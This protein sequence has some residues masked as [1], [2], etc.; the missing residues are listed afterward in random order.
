MNKTVVKNHIRPEIGIAV[1][2]ATDIQNGETV[3]KSRLVKKLPERTK[4][5]LE[6]NGDH[7]L[8]DEPGVL[9]NHSCSP[10]CVLIENDHNGFDFI[11][12]RDVSKDEEIT[13]DYESI[14]S[15]ISAFKDCSCGSAECRGKMNSS[16]TPL[17]AVC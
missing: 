4:Y 10:N 2:A 13:F 9:V 6:L 15:E 7:I 16:G 11:A 8:I 3:I 5:S 14:E 17:N 1:F 12:L